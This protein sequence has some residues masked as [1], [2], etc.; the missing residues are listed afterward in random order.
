MKKQLFILIL[1]LQSYIAGA[2][3]TGYLG[4]HFIA[5]YSPQFY[6]DVS[7]NN[8]GKV[9][10]RNGIRADAILGRKFSL[11]A[12]YCL[13][14]YKREVKS[15]YDPKSYM[16]NISSNRTALIF[17]IYGITSGDIMAPIGD[18]IRF[19]IY[20]DVFN[21]NDPYGLT[22]RDGSIPVVAVKGSMSTNGVEMAYGYSKIIKDFVVIELSAQ[23]NLYPYLGGNSLVKMNG[24]TGNDNSDLYLINSAI[25]TSIFSF[26]VSIGGLLF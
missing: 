7:D 1:L 22:R 10:V 18:F 17:T 2:Q 4:K 20:K 21:L 11:G 13:L 5:T 9:H 19:K 26:S 23:I 12:E 16:S 25:G 3:V 8:L 14:K 15:D 6:F 24:T